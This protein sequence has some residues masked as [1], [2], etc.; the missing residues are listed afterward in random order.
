[1]KEKAF[2]RHR[3]TEMAAIRCFEEALEE[4]CLHT[5]HCNLCPENAP[6]HTN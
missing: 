6:S 3:E 1:M 5:A 2:L 4:V